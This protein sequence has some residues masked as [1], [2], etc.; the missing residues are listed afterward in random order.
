MNRRALLL[1]PALLLLTLVFLLPVGWL[2]SR[3]FTYPHPGLGNVLALWR[4]PVLLRVLAN[5]VL[6]AAAVTPLAVLLGYPVAHAMAF[7]PRWLRRPLGFVVLLPFWSSLLVRT[8]AILVL[9][10]RQGPVNAVLTGLGLARA[11]V[12]MLYGLGAVLFGAVQVQVPFVVFPLLAVM[13]RVDPACMGAAMTLGA[14]PVR[15]F[16]RV[17]LPQTLPGVLAG[18]TLVFVTTLGYYV[19][20]ALLGG[21]HETMVAQLIQREVSDSGDWGVAGALSLLLLLVAGGLVGLLHAVVGLRAV[22]R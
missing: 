22:S 3:A 8:F 5:T 19:T 4:R 21:P 1:L 17:M 11:P 7:G 14:G 20:P 16:L 9:L 10:G 6:I 2:L 15:A 12:P 18:A 13:R